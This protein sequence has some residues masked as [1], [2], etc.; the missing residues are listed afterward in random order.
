MKRIIWV[1]WCSILVQSCN[2]TKST[3]TDE[4]DSTQVVAPKT[5]EEVQ[6][7]S[8]VITKFVRAYISQDQQKINALLHPDLGLTIIYRPGVA[9][10]FTRVD[11]IDFTKPVPE[12]F[13]YPKFNN[14][15]VLTFEKLPD[16]DCGTEKWS[17]EG[18]FCDTSR[19]PDQL[20]NIALFQ[21]EFNDKKFSDE[22]IESIK[23]NE[24][25]TY[26]I[27]LTAS[28]NLIFHVEMYQGQWY[29]TTLDRAYAGC[30]A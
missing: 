7:I 29:V 3:S 10:V 15:Y 5:V 18:F 19:H 9:D 27:V 22:Q 4:K 11:S 23:L 20:S 6:Q 1:I 8:E 28:E 25:N 24:K 16:Y 17:K 2:Q 21:K 30:D 12:Y 14:D 13:A 26:R